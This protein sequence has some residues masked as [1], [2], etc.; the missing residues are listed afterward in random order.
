MSQQLFELDPNSGQMT[1]LDPRTRRIHPHEIARRRAR[2]FQEGAGIA[3][4][5]AEIPDG[6]LIN[7]LVALGQP[8]WSARELMHNPQLRLAALRLWADVGAAGRGDPNAKERVDYV[9]AAYDKMRRE[10]LISDDP[11]R[12]YGD[13][14][15]PKELL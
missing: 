10:E 7:T 4:P 2:R 15:D 11:A 12:G 5:I 1:E 6:E 13:A 14:Y 9:R 3:A 8:R